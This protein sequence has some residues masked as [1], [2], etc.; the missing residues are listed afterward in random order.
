MYKKLLLSI[1][2]IL[3]AIVAPQ[4]VLAQV[5]DDE[6][7]EN[8]A[9][10]YELGGVK[11]VG[12]QFSDENALISV[13]GLK[14]G[15]K[16][17][18]PGI[19]ISKAIKNL[20]KLKL[21]TDVQVLKERTNGDVIFLEIV[22]QER[23]RYV[24]HSFKTLK[25]SYHDDVNGIINRYMVKG[26][27]VTENSKAEVTN[28][29]RKFF[30]EKGYLD[31]K[32][33]IQEMPEPTATNGIRLVFDIDRADRVKVQDVTFTGNDNI[34]KRKLQK[35]MEKTKRKLKIFSSS[36]LVQKDYE[37]D[38]K[39]IL[40]YYNKLGY[41]D[42][43][44]VSD[45]TWREK[46]GD[47]R[48]NIK[49]SEGKKYYFRDIVWKGNSIYE[50]EMLNRVFGIKKGD[51]YNQELMETRLRYSQDSRD[52]SSLYM[53]NGYLFFNIEPTEV[54][55]DKDSIDLEMRMFEGPQATIDKVII[56][57]NDRTNEHVIRR[58]LRTKPGQKFSRADIIRSQREIINLGYFNPEKLG[59]N[60]PVNVQRG[61][62]DVEYDVEEKPSDQL[63]LSAGWG[64]FSRGVIGTLGV[65]FNNFSL[66]NIKDRSTW[67]P[68][69]QG[70]GQKM[71]LR[72][73][74]NGKFYQSYNMSFTEP[75]LGGKKPT[76][77][78]MGAYYT[79]LDYGALNG[80]ADK[81]IQR[82]LNLSIGSRL[83]RPDDNFVSRTE[84]DMKGFGLANYTTGNLPVKNGNYYDFTIKQTLARST[85]NDPLFPREGSNFSL[86]AAFTLPY[87]AFR[88][89]NKFESVESK[90]KYLE[91]H[92][93][94]F[95]AE[96]YTSLVGK[97]VLKSYTKF[98]Y[99]GY[100]NDEIGRIPFNRFK[101]G[102]NGLNNQ[103][104]GNI[105]LD[106]I[107][108]RGYTDGNNDFAANAQGAAVFNK[109][110]M[111]LRYPI[112][113]N[114]QSTIFVLAFAEG[115]NAYNSL[116]EFKPFDFK[117]SAGLGARV[118][119]PMFGMLGFDY[120][121]GFDKGINSFKGKSL[122]DIGTFNII[123]GFEPE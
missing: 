39:S 109:M 16:I 101:Y 93:W 68:L 10:E 50:V 111:E 28:A 106:I 95:N 115:G 86:S 99:L 54:A 59:M 15:Q 66:R 89:S 121:I 4:T 73:Q 11:V 91:Y 36:K 6:I 81:I 78:S 13:A 79:L 87:S 38:K 96:W 56:R 112:S 69:P 116:R 82:G 83:K 43:E 18:I 33:D 52:V 46:D 113:L 57:G 12:A 88:S 62:V 72:A 29:I 32:I 76:S 107:S 64:G 49:L 84:L 26:S 24:K 3:F 103:T 104:F 55:I 67:S 1:V 14:V 45:S 123:I 75:W 122:K 22:V 17:R 94:R 9:K 47:L 27:I 53:D 41:R 110:G 21:F 118:F 35:K 92:K 98:G 117:R 2:T 44:I 31:T 23:P 119:L 74:T 8:N 102:G 34:S 63:E 90:F 37:E 60:T 20:W 42:A 58:E 61:T 7:K 70:D 71:S 40:K 25:K 105:G 19:D 65:S 30:I 108:G 48:I 100:Y 51:I 80:R 77:F 120:G 5:G 97:L 114:P 85:V